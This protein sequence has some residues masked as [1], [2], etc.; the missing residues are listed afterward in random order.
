MGQ[1]LFQKNNMYKEKIVHALYKNW[2]GCLEWRTIIPMDIFFGSNQYHTEEQWLMVV[3]D[4]DKNAERTYAIK[5]IKMWKTF[6]KQQNGSEGEVD[7]LL[8]AKQV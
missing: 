7:S 6:S 3:W 1:V 2:K 5:D 4:L 8:S